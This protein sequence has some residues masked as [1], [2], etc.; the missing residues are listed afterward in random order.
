MTLK[1]KMVLASDLFTSRRE[2]G[3]NLFSGESKVDKLQNSIAS[4]HIKAQLSNNSA[5]VCRGQLK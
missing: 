5:E 2:K 1:L 3:A 4:D